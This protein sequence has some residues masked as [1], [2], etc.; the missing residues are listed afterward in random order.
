[1]K[2]PQSKR[3]I[4]LYCFILLFSI[5]LGIFCFGKI[6]FAQWEFLGS[7]ISWPTI[8]IFIPF[9]GW[10]LQ[11]VTE[12]MVSFA[13]YNNFTKA[14]AIIQG[15]VIMRDVCN[16]FFV[17]VLL[18]IAYSTM[19]GYQ[20][21]SYKA[22]LRD[23]LIYAI[24]INFSKTIAGLF[25]D[26]SQVVMITFVNGF[27]QI[28]GGNIVQALQL[29]NMM[30]LKE[31]AKGITGTDL[32]IA[33]V[34]S[35]ALIIIALVTIVI[36]TII[37]LLRIVMLWL[38]VVISPIAFL[39][40]I[41]PGAQKYAS[42]W[43]D[44]FTKYL[45]VGPV[46]A[47][48]IWLAFTT[49]G[50]GNAI[51]EMG[52]PK[53]GTNTQFVGKIA[54]YEMFGSY[55]IALCMLIGGL[56]MTGSLGVAGGSLAGAAANKAMSMGKAIAA[57]PVGAA[58]WAGKKGLGG[59]DMAEKLLY[60]KTGWGLN[61]KR[62]VDAWRATVDKRKKDMEIEGA[63]V[64][65]SKAAERF[66]KGEWKMGM[67]SLGM[68]AQRD[69]MENYLGWR[70][71]TRVKEYIK[72]RGDIL[73]AKGQ[74]QK[75]ADYERAT[76]VKLRDYG[77]ETKTLVERK[78]A[79]NKFDNDGDVIKNQAIIAQNTGDIA[80]TREDYDTKILD[81]NEKIK[82][83]A[84]PQDRER[85]E[86]ER[87]TLIGERDTL[88]EAAQGTIN[89]AQG[90]LDA[91]AKDVESTFGN[92]RYSEFALQSQ[93]QGEINKVKKGADWHGDQAKSHEEFAAK[94]EPPKA[95][96]AMRDFRSMVAEKSGKL[97]R[98]AMET[99][100]VL[101]NMKVALADRDKAQFVALLNKSAQDYND[102]E[103]WNGFGY[104]GDREGIEKFRKEVLMDRL[105]MNDQESM[106]TL[107]DVCYINEKT[108]HYNASRM[109]RVEDGAFQVNDEVEQAT[110]VVAEML[111][112]EVRSNYRD[113]NR[114][115]FGGETPA[116]PETP[117]RK[118]KI[119]LSGQMYLAKTGDQLL[120]MLKQRPHEL[121]ANL[122]IKLSEDKETLKKMEDKKL[123][124]PELIAELEKFA[125]GAKKGE[126]A[127]AESL[128]AE[129]V[130]LQELM[131]QKSK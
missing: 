14:T 45:I 124:T 18:I 36:M 17:V 110:A 94:L 103:V 50:P 79:W 125:K 70:G 99:S 78:E 3:V 51:N 62:F 107:N 73:G 118:F 130:K 1:M 117:Y 88:I 52:T 92:R 67:L 25:I 82:S 96:Y 33:S 69:F 41:F 44:M 116:T 122:L 22:M 61:P 59:V 85:L 16:G 35:L 104:N 13:Q 98:E 74:L 55:V 121:N 111:K 12:I 27:I 77:D 106:S 72:A 87:Q 6:T 115:G 119:S 75:K 4:L 7:V 34:L 29:D 39:F 11:L 60:S 32:A 102:N 63:M 15:W 30:K 101:G 58:L 66:K 71:V 43:W 20:K 114:L 100:E 19:I 65:G 21:Y 48:F 49:V 57:A 109:Y 91:K 46:M 127:G 105:G 64:A 38:L 108:R 56:I 120:N 23:F 24:L 53:P 123:I 10:L 47:F 28:A 89:E 95:F 31:D 128:T 81:V 80:K 9:F 86:T 2:I 76:A 83:A 5:S 84:T 112:R 37:F 97:P 129:V 126:L 42:Q 54:S 26:L 90:I 68:G 131:K 93:M 8:N 113:A 40:P